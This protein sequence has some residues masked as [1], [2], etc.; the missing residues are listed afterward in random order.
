MLV[1]PSDHWIEEEDIFVKDI[2]TCF[3]A[4]SQSD[5]LLTLG[6]KPQFP[7]TGYG[8]I[9]S[10]DGTQKGIQKV[11]QFREKPD[12]ETAKKFIAAGNF[13]WNAGIFVWSVESITKAFETHLPSMY[14]LF[15]AGNESYNTPKEK[16]FIAQTYV[17]AENISIDYGILEKASNV[18]VLPAHFD[19]SDLGTWGSLHNKLPKD[20]NQN[21]LVRA[22]GLFTDSKN[23]M[24]YTSKEKLVVLDSIQDHIIVDK[25]NVLLIYP[26]K[27]EQ[28]IKEVLNQINQ[29][30]KDKY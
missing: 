19:W 16:E 24:I 27:K 20:K 25:E 1:A 11:K 30:Y 6:I 3:E 28:E 12:Y 14:S 15:S 2:Q 17:Q 13:A 9:E 7:N 5:K 29:K 23:N 8:Y 4:C 10:Q 18:Y 21:A 22:D 26:M